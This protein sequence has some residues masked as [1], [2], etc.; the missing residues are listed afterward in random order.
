MTLYAGQSP[1]AMA[2]ETKS[3][4]EIVALPDRGLQRWFR[5]R[6]RE[7]RIREQ[8]LRLEERLGERARIARELHDTLLQGFL[9]ATMLLHEAVEKVPAD[10]PAKPSLCRAMR[11]MHR[12]I[13]EGRDALRG[14]RSSAIASMSLEQALSAIRDEFTVGNGIQFRTFVKGEPKTLQPAI[15]EQIYLIGR[16]AL[17]NALRH[18]KATCIEVEVEYLPRWLRVLVRDNGCGIDSRRLGAVAAGHALGL[19]RN[20]RAGRQR[21]ALKLRIWSR[22]PG[23][24]TEVE[25]SVLSNIAGA[26]AA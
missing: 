17:V 14:L 4:R 5:R 7:H 2:D 9:G 15:Q 12:V 21:W 8:N 6:H 23:A 18:S 26:A 10:S 22:P 11:L 19:A 16:E 13:D 25:I 3:S 24:G 1:N 20:A